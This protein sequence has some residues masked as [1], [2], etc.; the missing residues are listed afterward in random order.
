MIER[1]YRLPPEEQ[2]IVVVTLFGVAATVWLAVAW[3]ELMVL[4]ALPMLAGMCWGLIRLA[5]RRAERHK[6]KLLY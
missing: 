3:E 1:Y 5:R 2:R 4:I 6:E